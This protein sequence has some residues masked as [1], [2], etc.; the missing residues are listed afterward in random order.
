MRP[1]APWLR[2][3]LTLFFETRK[4]CEDGCSEKP[5][6]LACIDAP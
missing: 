3:V 2:V 6:Q 1:L 4:R 5:I